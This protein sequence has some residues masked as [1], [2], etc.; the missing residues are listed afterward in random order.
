LRIALASFI[1]TSTTTGMGKWTDRIAEQLRAR[2]H[3]VVSATSMGLDLGSSLQ[4]HLFGVGVAMWLLRRRGAFDVA[5]VHEPHALPACLARRKTGT[6]VVVMSHGVENRIVHDLWKASRQGAAGLSMF[7]LLKH[8]ALWGWREAAAFRVAPQAL[9]LAEVDRSYLL[10]HLGKEPSAVTCFING[11]DSVAQPFDAGAHDRVLFLG[12]WIPEK[13]SLVLPRIWRAVRRALPRALL[14]V[15]GSALERH[16]VHEGFAPED[17]SSVEV[18]PAFAGAEELRRLLGSAGIFVLPSLREGSP[19]ALLE[20]MSHGLAPVASAVGG[21]PDIVAEG[22]GR[23]YSP[24]DIETGARHLRTL[25]EDVDLRRRMGSAAHVR[26]RA[27][28]WEAAAAVVERACER[29]IES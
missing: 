26:A 3:E 9:C 16:Q 12:T 24:L 19:L 25:L 21:V 7:Q 4:R 8:Y 20:A 2:G 14:T 27:C 22:A 29:A 5:I 15:A 10:E 28:T 11:T 13:G 1:A 23:L 17:R 6:A 18:I